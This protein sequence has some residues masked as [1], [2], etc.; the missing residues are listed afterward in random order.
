MDSKLTSALTALSVAITLVVASLV[1]V[2]PLVAG[3][4]AA[5]SPLAFAGTAVDAWRRGAGAAHR[6]TEDQLVARKK[7]ARSQ[8]TCD[9]ILASARAQFG[10]DGYERTTIRSVATAAE[11]DPSLVLRYFGSKDGLFVAATTFDLGLP[12][13]SAVPPGLHGQRLAEHFVRV[14]RPE[15]EGFNGM[16]ILLRA[17]ATHESA[18]ERLL[19]IFQA[20]VHPT[21]AKIV[22]DRVGARAAL[23]ATQILGFAYCRFIVKFPALTAMGVPSLTAQ[24]GASIQRCLVEPL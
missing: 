3:T 8:V 19:E 18:A 23:V 15:H 17:A 13:L 12:D 20:Q 2:G 24:L 11:I 6:M 14:W 4:L 21:I 10:A 16:A 5:I 9:R 1:L 22:S 7:Q